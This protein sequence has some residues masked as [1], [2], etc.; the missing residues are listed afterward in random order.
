MDERVVVKRGGAVA[1][2]RWLDRLRLLRVAPLTRRRAQHLVLDGLLPEHERAAHHRRHHL[3]LPHVPIQTPA[4][5]EGRAIW[6][7]VVGEGREE[8]DGEQM[9]A[10]GR[11]EGV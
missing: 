9:R 1:D 6:V 10:L 2:M 4:A 7:K 3:V 11:W 8:G 5:G